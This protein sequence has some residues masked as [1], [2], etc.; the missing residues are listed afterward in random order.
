VLRSIG[1]NVSDLKKPFISDLRKKTQ[2]LSSLSISFS[3]E[4]DSMRFLNP[5]TSRDTQKLRLAGAIRVTFARVSSAHD[6]V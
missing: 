3:L 1:K 6:D 4:N 5:K 2:S